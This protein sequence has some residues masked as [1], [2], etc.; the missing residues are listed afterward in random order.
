MTTTPTTRLAGVRDALATLHR[1]LLDAERRDLE[2]E[3][4]RIGAG[5]YLQLLLNEPRFEWLRPFSR[6]I[7]TID[8]AMHEAVKTGAELP[9]DRVRD[10]CDQVARVVAVRTML[11][12]GY[13]YRDWMQ[14]DPDVVLAHAALVSAL[15]PDR[16]RL[17]A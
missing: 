4:G 2:R 12:A 5:A 15:K 10:L 1:A 16:P 7:A 9:V 6:M 3:V 14:R 17:A 13:R 11:E 8:G